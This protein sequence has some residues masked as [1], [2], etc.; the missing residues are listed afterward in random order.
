MKGESE[1]MRTF[2]SVPVENIINDIAQMG[3]DRRQI[4]SVIADMQREGKAID[5]NVVISRCL[6]RTCTTGDAC[7]MN[8]CISLTLL[9]LLRGVLPDSQCISVHIT[10]NCSSN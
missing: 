7:V 4:M 9:S 6:G 2:R 3:F 5:L 8:G 10:R 1:T